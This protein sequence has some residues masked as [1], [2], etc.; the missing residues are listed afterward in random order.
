MAIVNCGYNPPS[1]ME[2]KAAV[3]VDCGFNPGSP[4]AKAPEIQVEDAP[5]STAP[6]R[7]R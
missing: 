2:P 5:T 7:K 4:A 6:K 1:K 3:E